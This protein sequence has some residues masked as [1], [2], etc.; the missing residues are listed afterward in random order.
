MAQCVL[1]YT[2]LIRL[3]PQCHAFT[4]IVTIR[5][6]RIKWLL[7]MQNSMGFLCILPKK[8]TTIPTKVIS[9]KL[10]LQYQKTRRCKYYTLV[11][12][13]YYSVKQKHISTVPGSLD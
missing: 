8:N 3:A 1:L 9:N 13:Q 5:T 10:I 6:N 7:L 12:V 11:I 4:Y 2:G